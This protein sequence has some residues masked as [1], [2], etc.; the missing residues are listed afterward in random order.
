LI[1]IVIAFGIAYA[2]TRAEK[3][4]RFYRQVLDNQRLAEELGLEFPQTVKDS[5]LAICD[6]IL[7]RANARADWCTARTAQEIKQRILDVR[8]HPRLGK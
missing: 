2:Q 6:E 3:E 7:E 5:H 1:L 4:D 8:E